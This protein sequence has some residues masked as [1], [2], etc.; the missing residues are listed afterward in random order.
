[1]NESANIIVNHDFSNGLHS[2]H[3]NCCNG[4]VVSA[5][6]GD[7]GKPSSS[8]S[9]GNYAVVTNRTKCWQ[10]LEQDITSRVLPGSTYSVS[11]CVGV[12][13]P[14]SGSTDVLATLKLENHGSATSYMLIG[15]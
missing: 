10:G 13:G 11:A 14:L 4:F 2:W 12:S 5:E 1:M 9:G 8:R 6:C 3:A 7:R 15:K